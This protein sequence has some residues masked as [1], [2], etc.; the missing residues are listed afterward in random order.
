MN[1]YPKPIRKQL[2]ELAGLAH[3]RELNRELG[4]LASDFDKWRD[5]KIDCFELN[6]LIHKFH[7][8]ISR[9]LWNK[10]DLRHAG[11]SVAM[12]IVKNIIKKEEVPIKTFE[13]I[14]E[15]VES[16]ARL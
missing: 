7:N 5:E 4:K 1:D 3:Q 2:G 10:Y 15:L 8:G 9:D 12:A 16:C 11:L 6:E 14:K 13:H